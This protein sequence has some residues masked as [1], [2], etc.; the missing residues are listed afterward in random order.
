M[1]MSV[2]VNKK[3]DNRGT[4]EYH[5]VDGWYLEKSPEHYR[6]HRFHINSTIRERF[7]DT[8]GF[9][10]RKFTRSTITHADKVIE[11]IADC[12]KAIKILGNGNGSE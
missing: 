5:T 3:T 11:A 10:H 9:N 2:Q 1:G 8:V 4:W 6:A 12:A 7:T